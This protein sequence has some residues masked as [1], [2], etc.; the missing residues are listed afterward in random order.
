MKN[1]VAKCDNKINSICKFSENEFKDW[2][3]KCCYGKDGGV[4]CTA[5]FK[6]IEKNNNKN[7]LEMKESEDVCLCIHCKNETTKKI[8]IHFDNNNT[9]SFSLCDK[10]L[11]K[12][13]K[14][15]INYYIKIKE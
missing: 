8:S 5:K 6:L 1:Y 7:M 11:T 3:G 2:N 10:C 12:L 13:T 15:F 9:A 4:Y 14:E